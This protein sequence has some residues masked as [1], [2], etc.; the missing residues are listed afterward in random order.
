[1][2]AAHPALANA[3]HHFDLPKLP[4]LRSIQVFG[5]TIKYYDLGD[6][7]PLLLVHGLGAEADVWA[8]CLEPLSQSYRVIALD[9]LGFGRSSKPLINY[10]VATFVEVLDRFLH[11]LEISQLSVVG[12][13]L[14]GWISAAFALRFPERVTKL[15]LND[16]IGIAAGAEE[17]P[18]DFRPSSLQNMR[19]VLEF[20]FY[21]KTLASDGLVEAAYEFHL[22][23]NDGPTI[24]V[25][26]EAI[27][28]RLDFLDGELARLKVPTLLVWGDSDRVSPLSVAQNYQRLIPG[29]KLEVIPQCGHIPPL[30]KPHELIGHVMSFL[31]G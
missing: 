13:S 7:P 14:G 20:M 6:G 30:E 10:R 8:Y 19:D 23:R 28:Q 5:Q 25:L 15:V 21:D 16:A 3:A 18:I 11:T 27:H 29:A 12:N 9:L 17:V 31:A 26:L 4:A 22:E 1:M 24:A 2:I